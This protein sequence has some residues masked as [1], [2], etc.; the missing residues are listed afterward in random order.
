RADQTTVERRFNGSSTNI[1]T[2]TY[3]AAGN[4]TKQKISSTITTSVYDAANRLR[5]TQDN[6]GITT[7][8]FDADGNQRSMTSPTLQR[9]TFVW[10]FENQRTV[11]VLPSLARTT[12]TYAPVNKKSVELPVARQTSSGTGN[13]QYDDQNVITEISQSNAVTAR[14]TLDPKPFGNLISQRRGGTVS[15]FYHFDA[16]DST[17]ALTDSTQTVTDTFLYQ[18]FGTIASRT[19]G[20][21][22][23]YT[24]FGKQGYY[25]DD[26]TLD[27]AL[28]QRVLDPTRGR[29][30]SEDPLGFD[31]DESNLYRYVR[32]NAPNAFDPSGEAGARGSSA[33]PQSCA[34]SDRN[35]QRTALPLGQKDGVDIIPAI[36]S[37][38]C[39][40]AIDLPRFKS[41]CD[42]IKEFFPGVQIPPMIPNKPAPPNSSTLLRKQIAKLRDS[43]S[44]CLSDA[45][46]EFN[47]AKCPKPKIGKKFID[48]EDVIIFKVERFRNLL[49]GLA[50]C[51]K[52][53][54]MFAK[55][56]PIEIL[57]PAGAL[58]PDIIKNVGGNL[59]EDLAL[60]L[61]QAG[62]ATAEQ[63]QNFIFL[64]SAG[65]SEEAYKSLA[66]F[67]AGVC[68]ESQ[69][70]AIL[71]T[72]IDY[73]IEKLCG[74]VSGFLQ[75]K[76]ILEDP[77]FQY[78]RLYNQAVEQ[79]ASSPAC[80]DALLGAA[81]VAAD[82]AA[83]THLAK[84]MVEK[85]L[86]WNRQNDP[87]SF[88]LGQEAALLFDLVVQA[89]I[90]FVADLLGLGLFDLA[91]QV[92]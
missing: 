6:T 54:P 8:T 84:A 58:L 40:E 64:Y 26:Q 81:N 87:Y 30:L 51:L 80:S 76:I 28:R 11:A 50:S 44:R 16:Q 39:R 13:F 90:D 20:T 19:G 85:V 59:A 1:T 91:Q 78:M 63:T 31:A 38:A 34:V 57:L 88:A 41:A 4:R 75:S 23:P 32:N 15:A 35:N 61:G 25:R 70:I 12:Y 86:E 65:K 77:D 45:A 37:Q 24:F 27:F 83:N 14:Y 52:Q 60:S 43:K 46:R 22:T 47:Q 68:K 36:A 62:A 66:A 10:N 67:M 33:P 5:R 71:V 3:D 7:F 21:T 82:R 89:L 73:E 49:K 72:L 69:V 2:W 53:P 48:C 42:L 17:R 29:F 79:G 74:N 9:T 92:L 55:Y 18:T 56:C